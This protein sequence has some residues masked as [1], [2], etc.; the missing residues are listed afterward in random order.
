MLCHLK[1]DNVITI[2]VNELKTLYLFIAAPLVC[3][4]FPCV[5]APEKNEKKTLM[6]F[7]LNIS[8]FKKIVD[9]FQISLNKK[10]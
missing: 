8:E 6:G 10:M 3:Q 2:V 7:G 5:A 1:K 4:L 9:I